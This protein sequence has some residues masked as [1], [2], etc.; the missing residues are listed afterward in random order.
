[1]AHF[2]PRLNHI[3]EFALHCAPRLHHLSQFEMETLQC[4]IVKKL[5]DDLYP[6][7][8]IEYVSI[9]TPHEPDPDHSEHP[10]LQIILK[11]LFITTFDRA[12]VTITEEL[13]DLVYG[14]HEELI[15]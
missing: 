8:N 15:N 2:A 11:V 4:Y 6:E 5:S 12:V 1:M 3:A 14:T 10:E 7:G 9:T 13:V